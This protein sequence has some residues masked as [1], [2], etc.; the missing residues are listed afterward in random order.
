MLS[1]S[2]QIESLPLQQRKHELV[3]RE[4]WNTAIRLFEE[5]GFEPTTVEQIAS[6]AGLS[7]RTFFRYFASKEDVI[8]QGVETYGDDLLAA[9]AAMPPGEPSL[10]AICRAAR[11]L[12]E[13]YVATG[14]YVRIVMLI[15]AGSQALRGAQM[16]RFRRVEDG[17][18]RQFAERMGPG[19]QCARRAQLL[20]SVS[21]AAINIAFDAWL[22]QG[23]GPIGP[24]VEEMFAA[25]VQLA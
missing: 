23:G 20:A 15:I 11:P 14:K 13:Q 24:L 22:Q 10:A 1:L 19:P 8:L 17:L 3:R 25:A 21:L 16:L 7:S 18:V 4:I 9:V 12:V 2:S 6:A 5:R